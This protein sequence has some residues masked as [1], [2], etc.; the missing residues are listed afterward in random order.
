MTSQ[1]DFAHRFPQKILLAE[2]NQVN[3]KVALIILK[4]LGYHP[5]VAEN[6]EEALNRL[7]EEPFDTVLMDIH[8]PVMD[9]KEATRQIRALLPPEQ[10]P[11]ILALTANPQEAGGQSLQSI[12]MDG[13]VSK[14]IKREALLTALKETA[15]P[16][17]A[18]LWKPEAQASPKKPPGEAG[19]SPEGASVKG[20]NAGSLNRELLARTTQLMG[21]SEAMTEII[22]IFL[23]DTPDQITDLEVSLKGQT[24]EYRSRCRRIAHTLKSTAL[25]VGAERLSDRCAQLERLASSG[26]IAN[27]EARFLLLK[28]EYA[29]VSEHLKA[30]RKELIAPQPD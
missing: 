25:Q 14:P 21:T 3:R 15:R 16:T 13:F 19:S 1:E 27:P 30:Y 6:G 22:D 18:L 11:R 29:R 7:K 2:D 9:G 17:E 26:P 10:Q 20:Q 8:M 24:P 4:K 12:G 5:E 23:R 28:K